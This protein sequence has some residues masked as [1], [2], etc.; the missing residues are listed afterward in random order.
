MCFTPAAFVLP[1]IALPGFK[2][3]ELTEYV[4]PSILMCD[5]VPAFCRTRVQFHGAK[6]H[7]LPIVIGVAT[8]ESQTR[9]TYPCPV[10]S[11]PR[12]PSA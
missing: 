9:S 1:G 4:T 7:I 5:A 10:Q 12:A 8:T 11:T 2:A 6:K 3:H